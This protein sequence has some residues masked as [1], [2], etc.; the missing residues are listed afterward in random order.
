LGISA[1]LLKPINQQQLLETVCAS[2]QK[3]AG[4]Q[5]R[6]SLLTRHSIRESARRINILLAE[7]NL[8]N[9]KMAISVLQKMGHTVTVAQNG[10]QALEGA[11]KEQFDLI[12]MDVQMPEMDGLEATAAIRAKE[13][14]RG[15]P[16]VP[17]LAMTA[18]AMA[19]DSDRCIAAGM[20]GYISKPINNQELFETIEN[21]AIK[22]TIT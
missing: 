21:L 19:G 10:K 7:D 13:A 6:P 22:R 12:L 3:N 8:I 17:I 15:G 16:R 18:C 5:P 9:Q 2:L 1:Y 11:E 14:F 20:D 4:V